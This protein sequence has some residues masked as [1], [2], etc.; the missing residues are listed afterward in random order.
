VSFVKLAVQVYCVSYYH[1]LNLLLVALIL[2]APSAVRPGPVAHAS[3]S[4]GLRSVP[5]GSVPV[6]SVPVVGRVF[7]ADPADLDRL[8]ARLDVWHVV[9]DA[10][11]LVA[12]LHPDERA[13]LLQAGYRV[14]IDEAR[15][16]RLN[17][18]EPPLVQ[19]AGGIPSYPCYR[20]VEETY[21][22][23]AQLAAGHPDLATWT[24]IGDSWEKVSGDLPGY[25]LYALVLTN[26]ARPGPKPKFVLMGA[27]HARELTTAELAARFAEY[28]V[29]SYGIDPD[30][31]WLLDDFEVHIL[32]MANPDG[33]KRAEAGEYWRKNTDDDDGC[34]IPSYYG[35]DLNRNSS[36]HWGGASTNPCSQTYQGPSA[37]SEPETQ[38]IQDYLAAV[39]PDQRGPGDEDPTPDDAMGLFISLHSFGELVLFPYGFR[40]A[41]SSNDAQLETLGRKFGFFNGYEVCRSGEP[42]CIYTT[43]GTTDDWAYG[44]LGV[45]AYTFELGWDFFEDCSFFEDTIVPANFPALLYA[46]KAA[47]RPYQTPA[48]PEAL[49][50]V[51]TPSFVFAGAPVTVTAAIDDTRYD[52]HGWGDEPVQTIADA[53]YTVDAPSWI[54][55]TV[56]HPTSPTD[57]AF[58]APVETV[59]AAVD[60]TGWAPGRHILYVEGQ[61]AEGHRGVPAAVFLWI[62][63]SAIQGTAREGD[64]GLPVKGVTVHLSGNGLEQEQI[65]GPDGH[66]AF[67]VFTGTYTLAPSAPGYFSTVLTPVVA[68][69]GITTTQDIVL[70]PGYRHYL[71]LVVK[72]KSVGV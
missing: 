23:L 15:T 36:F 28:L 3:E 2:T 32:P 53:R 39:F 72:A 31:T 24:D 7:F 57:G 61:D 71:P 38:A 37:V 43:T 9:H 21:A 5:A 46:I 8:A 42:G 11:Y 54:T 63:D 26:R 45:A 25:A 64:S 51:A 10:G 40:S 66:Y 60:T 20:T 65:T 18:P 29:A 58:D 70:W 1:V 50:V 22:D 4:V 56:S 55:G 47:R 19:Q 14:E 49:D 12:L 16:A 52:S 35:T 44:E 27:I 48:G 33:R 41:P 30:V 13:A 34:T 67:A 68:L 17:Q 62:L 69:S 6:G 59:Q